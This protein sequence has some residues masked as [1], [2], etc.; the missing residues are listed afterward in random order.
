MRLQGNNTNRPG[1]DEMRGF[2]KYAVATVVAWML[3]VASCSTTDAPAPSP[4][5]LTSTTS[6]VA[7]AET[8][9]AIEATMAFV[10]ARDSRDLDA[11]LELLDPEAA[12]VDFGFWPR[13]PDEYAGLF[14]WMEILD[15]RWTLD[16]CVVEVPEPVVRVTCT[17]LTE[18][19]WS[20]ARELDPFQGKLEF[21]VE[22]NGLISEIT[23]DH[24]TW[25]D[26]V[27][28]PWFDWLDKNHEEDIPVM[29]R[30]DEQ[31]N[32]TGGPATTSG[33]LDLYR[34]RV[35]EYVEWVESEAEDE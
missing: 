25:N 35:P 7:P 20:R 16:E 9:E 5:E 34:V 21:V 17:Y 8:A 3:A 23:S 22:E 33:A 27:F 1:G 30:L 6:T 14:E 26:Q 19:A 2:Q 18:N 10:R 12:I 32:L 29:F 15:W 4:V 11:T 24:G 13:T 28:F 31:D